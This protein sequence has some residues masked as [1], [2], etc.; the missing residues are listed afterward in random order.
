MFSE[1]PLVNCPQTL[2]EPSG[3]QKYGKLR[4]LQAKIGDWD[5][6]FSKPRT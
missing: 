4:R 5:P 2:V 3:A 1:R 6:R